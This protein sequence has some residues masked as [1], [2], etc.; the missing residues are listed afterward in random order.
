MPPG[1]A[2]N[3]KPERSEC[4]QPGTGRIGAGPP[5]PGRM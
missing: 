4:G 5:G 3:R 1:P 2:A